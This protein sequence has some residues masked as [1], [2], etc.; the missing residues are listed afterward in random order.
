MNA[1]RAELV[2]KIIRPSLDCGEIVLCDRF[3]D[4]TCAYQ[5][6]G[7]GLDLSLVQQV[8]DAA[9][10][11]TKPNLTFLLQIPVEVSEE[12]RRRRNAALPFQ[13][14]RFEAAGREF[15]LRVHKGYDEIAAKEPERFRVINGTRTL[16]EV[17]A[18]IRQH[19]L[20]L[21]DGDLRQA[22][23]KL[24]LPESP[25]RSNPLPRTKPASTLPHGSSL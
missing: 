3:Y 7:R 8:E 12:R 16:E 1:S 19:F 9:V 10:G 5:G 24:C 18:Q 15:F 6:Y 23:R 17:Q 25:S 20:A 21:M 13:F 4:S 2:R 11:E 22:S 14:D